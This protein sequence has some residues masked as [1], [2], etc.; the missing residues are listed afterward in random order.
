MRTQDRFSRA[1]RPPAGRLG[2]RQHA[3][4]K[5]LA[6]RRNILLLAASFALAPRA[7]LAQDEPWEAW[8]KGVAERLLAFVPTPPPPLA[9]AVPWRRADTPRSEGGLCWTGVTSGCALYYG[10]LVSKEWLISDSALVARVEGVQRRQD[11]LTNK[12]SR[13]TPQAELTTIL[14]EVG[15]LGRLSDSLKRELGS[16]EFAITANDTPERV[17]GPGVRA[18]T[19]K[20]YPSY[21]Q[22]RRLAVYVGPSGFSNP[23][24]QPDQPYRTQLKSF[25]VTALLS[26]ETPSP[27]E[28]AL[29]RQ[30]LERVD[31]AALAKLLQP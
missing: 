12:V 26:R 19:L 8:G 31:Y 27:A 16:I 28:E 23:P 9:D 3:G 21:R 4:R 11:S 25:L 10:V 20:G 1:C 6:R 15:S 18:G 30:L 13:Q 7:S 24:R 22:D 14:R 5:A 17:F 29:A 2:D